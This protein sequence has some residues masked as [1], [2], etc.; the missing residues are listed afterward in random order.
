[1]RISLASLLGIELGKK[2]NAVGKYFLSTA[3]N[4]STFILKALMF[5]LFVKL[6]TLELFLSDSDLLTTFELVLSLRVLTLC[7]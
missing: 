7:T 4:S 5:F 6:S 3:S 1:M 2:G